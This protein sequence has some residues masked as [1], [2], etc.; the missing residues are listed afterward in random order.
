MQQPGKD[1]ADTN[2]SCDQHPLGK[3]DDHGM[4]HDDQGQARHHQQ[5]GNPHD[6]G[7]FRKHPTNRKPRAHPSRREHSR[8]GQAIKPDRGGQGK[9]PQRAKLEDHRE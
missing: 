1:H 8:I 6:G 9:L 2:S 5:S 4:F 3:D 7:R